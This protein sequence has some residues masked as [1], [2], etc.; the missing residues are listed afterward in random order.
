M[1]FTARRHL[2][3]FAGLVALTL[4]MS[5]LLAT[6]FFTMHGVANAQSARA[7]QA[8]ARGEA[9]AIVRHAKAPHARGR[10]RSRGPKLVNLMD[11]GSQ[12][13]LSAAGRAQARRIG[14]ALRRRGVANAQV[15][16]S[17]YCR[18]M[19]TAR[20]LGFGWVSWDYD[21]NALS[22]PTARQQTAGLRALVRGA[23]R[24]R[25]RIL[26]THKTNIRALT[27]VTPKSGETLIVSRTG[28]VI[29]RLRM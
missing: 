1:T 29:G 2:T 25:P 22:R 9:V 10:R 11:C 21:L 8:L 26:V 5:A 6:P 13:N 15:I 7:W 3:V 23:P 19:E 18:T 27:G 4:S 12:R 24:G 28:K 16:S 17:Y 20:L 14:A